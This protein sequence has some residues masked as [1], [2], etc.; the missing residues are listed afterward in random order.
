MKT[1]IAKLAVSAATY[2]IDKPYTYTIPREMAETIVPG[3]RVIVPFGR[4][5]RKCEAFVLATGEAEEEKTLKS[6]ESILDD[7]PVLEPWQL[8]L[9]M[10]MGTRFFCTVY[11]AARTMLPV[12]MWYKDGKRNV[13]DKTELFAQLDIPGDEALTIAENIKKR[14]PGKAAILRL[15]AEIGGAWVSE[16]T[17]FTGVGRQSVTR[18]AKDGYVELIRKEVFRRPEIKASE[19]GRIS[20]LNGNQQSVLNGLVRQYGEGASAALLY[21]IT[22]SGK[23]S[24]YIKLIEHVLASGR[25]AII[26]VPEISLTPQLMSIFAA[27]F[28]DN[29]AVLHS[30]LGIGE[31][32]DEWKR[33]KSGQVHVVIGTRSAVFAPV[34]NLGLIVLDEEQEATYK[35]ENSPRY[36]AREVAK[37]RCAHGGAMLLLGSATP[38]VESMHSALTG[39]YTL[40][41]LTER[42][43]SAHLPEVMTVDMK[44]ELRSGNGGDISRPL[45][46]EIELN[47][48]NGQQTILFLNRR[49]ASSLVTCGACGYTF[50]CDRC[51]V[52][53]TYHRAN[54]RLMCHYCGYSRPTSDICPQCGSPLSYLGSGTQKVEEELHGLFPEASVIRMDADTVSAAKSHEKILQEFKDRRADI[55]LGTQMVTKGLDFENVTLVGVLSADKSL[56]VNDYRARERTFS[57]I[58]QVVGRAGRGDKPGRAVIQTFTP[59]NPVIVLASQQDYDGFYSDEIAI[60]RT[61][62][63]PPFSSLFTITASGITETDVLR[64]CARVKAALTGYLGGEDIKILGPAPALVTKINNRFRYRITVL[65]EDS[66]K[67]RDT[68]SHV[69]KLAS[70]DKICRGVAVYADLDPADL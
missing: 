6:V 17:Y 54:R 25:D 50:T 37:Y 57:M 21:G 18:L 9:A 53:L 26:L 23:T 68:I 3:M 2:H 62:H 34:K 8:K 35:S 22:G 29:I 59:D 63:M 39:K 7:E 33:I 52:S 5:N 19:N 24:I 13:G 10:W 20:E 55:L 28:G 44:E 66:K 41:K 56:Y 32:Y 49:G 36:H 14:S 61:M 65:G 30:M 67:L 40:Y 58:T 42:F 11:E 64:A 12:G 4:G 69:V 31:R 27:N 48:K 46:R 47:I 16:I 43:N 51:S 45:A 1:A 15:L 38:S 60:R 70:R